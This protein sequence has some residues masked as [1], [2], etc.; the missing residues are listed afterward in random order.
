MQKGLSTTACSS[1]PLLIHHFDKFLRKVELTLLA[2]RSRLTSSSLT[3]YL[4]LRSSLTSTH[5]RSFILSF[6]TYSILLPSILPNSSSKPLPHL[7]S[8]HHLTVLPVRPIAFPILYRDALSL[9]SPGIQVDCTD[10]LMHCAIQ[11]ATVSSY[12]PPYLSFPCLM[13]TIIQSRS[14]RGFGLLPQRHSQWCLGLDAPQ[15]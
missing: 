15:R 1:L 11:V 14:K 10:G 8:T 2:T 7:A 6:L 3:T 12:F 5:K 9:L 13:L 4:K